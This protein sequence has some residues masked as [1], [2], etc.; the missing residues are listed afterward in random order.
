V[1]SLPSAL[2]LSLLAA[3]AA[4]VGCEDEKVA[5]VDPHLVAQPESIDLGDVVVGLTGRAEIQ[6]KNTGQ[7]VLKILS[8]GPDAALGGEFHLEG[9][10]ENLAAGGES[11][12]MLVFEPTSLGVREGKLEFKTD[13]RSTPLVTVS[14]TARGVEPSL[15]AEPPVVDFGRVVVGKTKTATVTLLNRG[16]NPLEVVRATPDMMTSAEFAPNV[17]R[18]M[19]APGERLTMT[20]SYT[21]TDVG[22]DEGRVIII[23]SSARPESLG[24]RVRGHGVESDIEIDPPQ[25]DFT[26]LYVGQRQTKQFYLRNIGETAHDITVL[27]FVSTGTTGAPEFELAA[28]TLPLH[29]LPG[30]AEQIDV[31]YKPQ[32]IAPDMD[33]VQIESDGL[34][35][36]GYVVLNGQA[37]EEPKAEIEVT[38]LSLAFGQIEL[39]MNR[40]LD[41]RITNIGTKDLTINAVTLSMGAVGYTLS[42]L[43]TNGQIF[44]PRDSQAFQVVFAPTVNGPA[45]AAE[46]VIDS[47]DLTDPSVHVTLSGEG[48]THSVPSITVRPNPVDFGHVPRGTLTS[49][50]ITVQNDG[51]A[52]LILSQVRLTNDAGARFRLPMPPGASTTLMPTQQLQFN[53]DYFD[54]GVVASYSGTLEVVSNDPMRPTVSVPLTAATD[55]PPVMTTDISLVMTWTSPDTDLDLHLISPGRTLFN[56]PGDNCYCN[57]NPDWGVAGQQLD[58]PFLDRD[59]LVGPGP[60]NIN[61]SQAATGDYTVV[62]HYFSDHAH[63]IPAPVTLQVNLRGTLAATLS[64]TLNNNERW[65]AGTI[66]WNATTRTGTWQASALAPFPSLLT[67]C[68]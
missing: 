50:A 19:L 37:G 18:Q 30:G 63:G 3:S 53:V 29:I 15:V 13:S 52:A 62:V 5:P 54:A 36:T 64:R 20:I 41:V 4:S 48:V 67:T 2:L 57:T 28:G 17:T 7:A 22:M 47:D 39:G 34:P 59:D 55:P 24:I 27:S 43:P 44:H 32:N 46:V 1:R 49:R 51:T 9:V 42:N 11:I 68:L 21:P 45:P 40:S 26:G 23:D 61:L 60:E 25:L 6:L 8:A 33:R 12:I 35:S 31:T 58:N 10:E 56:T 38:P 66:H 16:A 14:V 65:T